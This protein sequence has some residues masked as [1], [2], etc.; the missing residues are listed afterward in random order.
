MS[1]RFKNLDKS[2]T[3]PS[4]VRL[5]LGVRRR[6]T[7]ATRTQGTRNACCSGCPNP[8]R[9]TPTPTGEPT[10]VRAS[11]LT[12]GA[13][14][15][16]GPLRLGGR[17]ERG[18]G[19]PE[20]PGVVRLR[21]W[22][23]PGRRRR[24]T[25][26][27]DTVRPALAQSHRWV[28]S[29]PW[30]LR[31]VYSSCVLSTKVY[32]GGDGAADQ[33]GI[34][35]FG[36]VEPDRFHGDAW[37][38]SPDRCVVRSQHPPVAAFE[39]ADLLPC[40]PRGCARRRAQPTTS[41]TKSAGAST[42]GRAGSQRTN[43]QADCQV[44]RRRTGDRAE[45]GASADGHRAGGQHRCL[46]HTRID[47]YLSLGYARSWRGGPQTVDPAARGHG[48]RGQCL[49]SRRPSSLGC[50]VQ[51]AGW[52]SLTWS[53]GPAAGAS[54]AHL[55][56]SLDRMDRRRGARCGIASTSSPWPAW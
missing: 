52:V 51:A 31:G 13:R 29:S 19:L 20:P 46:P 47:R 8:L 4:V 27:R 9:V 2:V 6:H 3:P 25:L 40:R 53:S 43:Q 18:R 34:D 28:P 5:A 22:R 21:V 35:P 45:I 24:L 26:G 48:A 15:V 23:L 56:R 44:H 38:P 49:S 16:R 54:Q 41:K 11:E 10:A 55:P 1:P 12:F 37:K 33:T 39:H 36:A 7:A 42:A 32:D 50:S 14:F 17:V 30:W